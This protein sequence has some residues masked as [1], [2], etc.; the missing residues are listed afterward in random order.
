M[1]D[2]ED[3]QGGRLKGWSQRKL[4]A[5]R[6]EEIAEETP[7]EA[8]P[9]TV[10]TPV[11]DPDVIAALPSLDD[12]TPDFDMAP[13]FAKGVP[14]HLKNAALRK[15]WQASPA[16]R[17]YLDPAVDYAWDWNA[18]GGV[19]GGGGVLSEQSVARMVKDIIGN[20]PADVEED[21]RADPSATVAQV[22]QTD[23][24]DIAPDAVRHDTQPKLE[25][26][27]EDENDVPR[28]TD[29]AA[30]LPLRRHGGATPE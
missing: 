29:H 8:V 3:I 9:N 20:R 6:Q 12:I 19:P 26:P 4:Q 18:P 24:P 11:D 21:E 13:F 27:H 28:S 5:S 2:P 15:L 1:S 7:V 30:L 17:D 22:D 25:K 14:A 16:V 10:E 23:E